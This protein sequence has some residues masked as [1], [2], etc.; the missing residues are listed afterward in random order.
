[1]SFLP[2]FTV[3]TVIDSKLDLK[4]VLHTMDGRKRYACNSCDKTFASVFYLG[5][6][7]KWVHGTEEDLPRCKECNKV[8][9]FDT[10]LRYHYEMEH[11]R[12]KRYLCKQCGKAFG[13]RF[14]LTRHVSQVH[15]DTRM[16]ACNLCD[17]TFK[18]LD[19][20]QV[21]GRMSLISSNRYY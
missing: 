21:Q 17:K 13:S 8:F 18:A 19:N 1:M 9:K 6:H 10:S 11:A 5:T 14:N 2:C 4:K 12:I 16:L 7:Q 15:S 20:L 3:I